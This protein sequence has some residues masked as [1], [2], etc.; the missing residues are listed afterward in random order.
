MERACY[1]FYGNSISVGKL[2]GGRA[3]FCV[4]GMLGDSSLY[5]KSAF[6]QQVLE[7]G[8]ISSYL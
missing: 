3:L 4:L 8:T 7:V 6:I 1:V 2:G 5:F